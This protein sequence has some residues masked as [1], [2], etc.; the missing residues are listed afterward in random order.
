MD[1][2]TDP[3]LME[4]GYTYAIVDLRGTGGSSGCQD[5]AGPGEQADV[6]EAVKWAAKQPWSNGRVAIYGKS[7]DGVT[8]LIGTALRPEGL[9]AVLSMEPVYDDYRYLYG[10]GMRRANWALTPALYDGIAASPG[11]VADTPNDPTYTINSVN[12]TQRPGCPVGNL[13]DQAANDDHYSPFWRKRNFITQVAGSNVP[14]FL[15]QGMTENNTAPDGLAEFLRNHTGPER[16]WLGPWNHVRG[17]QRNARGRLMMGREGWF[18]EVFRFFDKYLRGV[19]P[20][21]ADPNFVVQTN[22]GV[23]RPEKKWPPSDAHEYTT[24]LNPGTYSDDATSNATGSGSST[25][26][27]T[28][29][30]PLPHQAM[31]AGAP[32]AVVDVSS[33]APLANLVV[34]VY[35]IGPDGKGPL[36]SRQGHLIRSNGPI[37]LHMMSADWKFAAGHRIGVRV[38]D[39]NQ[40]WWLAAVPTKQTVTV[41]GGQISLP[42]LTYARDAV[43]PGDPSD[44]LP[45]YLGAQAT[46][47]AGTPATEGFALPPAQVPPPA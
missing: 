47:P 17:N 38:T 25:G 4:K 42:F 12:D 23:W 31:L 46:V 39:N 5:W 44:A 10:D 36:V 8:G 21:V 41:H 20:D 16:A 3:R 7:Y 22:D 18:D 13:A 40:D 34:D 35:D 9:S 14:L 32:T 43:L 30:P 24:E 2:L 1:F 26:V 28:V 11:P 19:K 6:V 33:A 15:T 45:E 29:S 37:T 27:W